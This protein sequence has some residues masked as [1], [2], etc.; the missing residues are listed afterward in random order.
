M[1]CRTAQDHRPGWMLCSDAA[2]SR[3]WQLSGDGTAH[4]L[5]GLPVACC[6][7]HNVNGLTRIAPSSMLS[8]ARAEPVEGSGLALAVSLRQRRMQRA[9]SRGERGNVPSNRESCRPVGHEIRFDRD[10]RWSDSGAVP[11]APLCRLQKC[12]TCVGLLWAL[13]LESGN[14]GRIQRCHSVGVRR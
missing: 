2:A 4:A 7:S 6:A 1:F 14:S 10:L 3:P 11:R 8:I 13:P 5:A 12:H 9:F